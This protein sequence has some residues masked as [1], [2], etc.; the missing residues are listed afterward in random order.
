MLEQILL[1]LE[2]FAEDFRQPRI[3]EIADEIRTLIKDSEV[4]PPN[5][6]V[7]QSADLRPMP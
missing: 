2:Q 1:E 3:K 7:V 6:S 5:E 4:Q